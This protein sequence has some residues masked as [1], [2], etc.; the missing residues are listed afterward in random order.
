MKYYYLYLISTLFV[1]IPI[2]A[3]RPM[4]SLFAESLGASIIEIGILTA[5]YS[6]LP[7]LI[8]VSIG[9]FIDQ[10]GSKIPILIGSFGMT[11]ALIIP[12]LIPNLVTLYFSQLL[13]GGAHF[14]A[15]VAI[16]HGI[17]NSV[18]NKKQDNAV[19]TLSLFVS[20]G[21]MLGPL[22]GGYSS[23]HLGFKS[24][25]LLYS[26]ITLFLIIFFLFS[27]SQKDL[28]NDLKK[29]RNVKDIL[30]IPGIKSAFLIS[31]L[32]LGAL[33]TF[34]VYFPLYAK[35]I[36]QTPTQIGWILAVHSL[37]SIITRVFI[38]K[39]I[40]RYGKFK[41]LSIFMFLG[42]IAYGSLSFI[43][44]YSTIFIITILF[45]IGLGIVQPLTIIITI[46]LAP[47]ERMG[48]ILSLRI[49]GNR[50]SQILMPLIIASITSL[51]GVGF[52]F[53]FN[54]IFLALG[55]LMTSVSNQEEVDKSYN[56]NDK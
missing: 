22:I 42:T 45:G 17:T 47:K 50:I 49:A 39:L 35:S 2:S 18:S 38:P 53:V 24:S 23:E 9:R 34:Y 56:H 51:I 6:F 19:A 13:L 25:Y 55:S 8:A 1:L 48:E 43:S 44:N 29:K 32:N 52:I 21:M 11:S 37:A 41:T 5:C 30:M 7:L 27:K 16:Q 31:M 12:F 46:S 15:F 4:T 54:S 14:L 40:Y 26:I 20:I 28:K 3:V 10:I 33:D 36:G